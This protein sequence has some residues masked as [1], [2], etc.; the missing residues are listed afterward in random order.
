MNLQLDEWAYQ[1]NF[2]GAGIDKDTGEAL[3]YQDLMKKDKYRDIW[4]NSLANELWRLAQG[5]RDVKVTNTI[6]FIY[7]S[8]IPKDRLKD[9]TYGRIVLA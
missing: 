6:L 3:E 8:E 7:K 1:E 5:I 2:S 4:S 9:T